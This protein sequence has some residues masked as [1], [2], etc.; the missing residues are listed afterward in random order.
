MLLVGIF[1]LVTAIYY[2]TRMSSLSDNSE[3]IFAF[4]IAIINTGLCIPSLVLTIKATKNKSNSLVASV[5]LIIASTLYF[6]YRIFSV[7]RLS[8]SA[9]ASGQSYQMTMYWMTYMLGQVLIGLLPVGLAIFSLVTFKKN[10][11]DY[12]LSQKINK[13]FY[14]IVLALVFQAFISY[15]TTGIRGSI[16]ANS[17]SMESLI[18]TLIYLIGSLGL[19]GL[20]TPSFILSFFEKKKD[21]SRNLM[22]IAALL[23]LGIHTWS[24]IIS[25]QQA[26]EYNIGT[27]TELVAIES[28]GVIAEFIV[29]I[30]SAIL[31]FVKFKSK[32][33]EQIKTELE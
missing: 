13:I 9:F 2:L 16:V 12:V 22:L 30:A 20:A 14:Y 6:G 17:S 10:E 28:V 26:S 32:E 3:L 24:L 4:V 19:I 15:S 11:Q 18:Q 27:L 21:V 7:A 29:L 8:Q 23:M 31:M 33:P 5:L 1:D 25:F